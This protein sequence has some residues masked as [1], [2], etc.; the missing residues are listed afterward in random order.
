MKRDSGKVFRLGGNMRESLLINS[1]ISDKKYH[2]NHSD[3]LFSMWLSDMT[4]NTYIHSHTHTPIRPC[5][6]VLG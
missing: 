6:P 3:S 1:A 5:E 4:A 2:H